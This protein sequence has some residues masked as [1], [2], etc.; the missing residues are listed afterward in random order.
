M[1]LTNKKF[2]GKSVLLLT[3][4]QTVYPYLEVRPFRQQPAIS[5][6]LVQWTIIML[7]CLHSI[8]KY[9]VSVSWWIQGIS[10][11]VFSRRYSPC[12]SAL[13]PCRSSCRWALGPRT[14]R[15]PPAWSW[16]RTSRC[17]PAPAA[18]PH[19]NP[20]TGR[21]PGSSGS[22]TYASRMGFPVRW[23]MTSSSSRFKRVVFCAT[24][25]T[26]LI[27]IFLPVLW[28]RLASC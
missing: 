25:S 9:K 6:H 28:W 10:A 5:V 7:R 1:S 27:F 4:S 13:P 8:L 23:D 20:R 18:C 12:W 22:W 15:R 24:L 19:R 16:R 21:Y 17:R 14:A 26:W 2:N 11:S 3:L